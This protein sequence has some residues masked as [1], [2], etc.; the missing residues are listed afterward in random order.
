M[1]G[2]RD[3]FDV[4]HCHLPSP[5]AVPSRSSLASAE[6]GHCVEGALFPAAPFPLEVW[7]GSGLVDLFPL[8]LAGHLLGHQVVPQ[9]VLQATAR[10]SAATHAAS[11]QANGTAPQ[12]AI[13]RH[14]CTGG[15]EKEEHAGCD[16]H[17]VLHGRC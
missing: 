1:G 4:F 2:L 17:D 13:V 9:Q 7:H 15:G 14:L 6:A 8:H 10:Q 16:E 12:A 5:A 3:D 11:A